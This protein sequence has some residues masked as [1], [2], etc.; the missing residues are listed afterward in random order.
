VSATRCGGFT[1]VELLVV[2]AIIGVLV[3]LLLPAVQAA[4]EASRRT[5]CLS[6]LRQITLAALNY[7]SARKKLPPHVELPGS[8]GLYTN[9]LGVQARLLPYMEQ[10]SV[11]NLVDQT[12][13]WREGRNAIAL[14]TPLPF[15]RCPSGKPTELTSVMVTGGGTTDEENALRSHYVGNMGARPGPD[16]DGA[17]GPGCTPPGGGRGSGTWEYP[18]VTYIQRSCIPRSA[19]S[20]GTALNGTIFP[21]SNLEIG[22]VSDGSSNTIMFGEMSW[23]VGPQAPWIVGSASKDGTSRS[24]QISS[25]H[26]VVFN[27]KNVR[28]GINAENYINED[29]TPNVRGIPLTE[30]SFG[31]YHPGG[32]NVALCDGS[33]SFLRDDTDVEAV[34]RPMASRASEDVYQRP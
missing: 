13:H 29:G 4:R 6:R 5:D 1:L 22:D 10:Q 25:A 8:E 9:G 33:A 11:R 7:E 32:A 21:L 16:E 24:Q 12:L 20:G 17:V 34:L 31:S 23:D 18:E 27:A 19:G 28:W 2:I 26:G 3:A 14:M 15:L 30:T